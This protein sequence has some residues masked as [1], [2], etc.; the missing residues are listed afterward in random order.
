MEECEPFEEA[1]YRGESGTIVV[2]SRVS[3]A[4]VTLNDHATEEKEPFM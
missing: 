2:V 1:V 3:R 4:A